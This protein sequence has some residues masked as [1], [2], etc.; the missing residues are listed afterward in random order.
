[1]KITTGKIESAQKV[2]VYGPEGIGKSTFASQFPN[3]LFI[4][5]E[6]STKHLDVR[7]LDPPESWTMLLQQVTYVR[8]NPDVCSTLIIDT[9]DWAEHLC[10]AHICAKAQVNGIEDFGYGKGY[11]YLAEEFGNLLNLLT[12]VV[13]AGVNVVLTAHAAIRKFEQPDE[14][15]AYDRWEL[16][17]QKKTAPLVREWSD[18]VLFA[19]YKTFVVKSESK[20]AKPQGGQRVMYT[21]HR[22]AWDAKN[23]HD[24]ADEIPFEFASI[25]AVIPAKAPTP[26]PAPAPEPEVIHKPGPVP[27]EQPPASRDA[28]PTVNLP[29]HM[30]KLEQLMQS[31]GV[32]EADVRMAVHSKGYFP[33][34]TAI[35]KYPADFVEGVLIAAWAKVLEIINESKQTS[36]DDVPFK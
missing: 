20:T 11:T 14:M 7:R 4:D 15:A 27:A 16:K 25:A 24:L 1:M 6:G 36:L 35:E 34:E 9:A 5:V 12:E 29:Q 18:M 30:V 28:A 2:L 19:T 17:L 23:R 26:K 13:D 3:A 8:L 33:E 32:S 31:A 10:V 22:P 21:A